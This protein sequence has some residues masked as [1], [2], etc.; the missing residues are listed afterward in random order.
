PAHVLEQKIDLAASDDRCR[1]VQD[2]KPH[3]ADQGFRDLDHLLIGKRQFVNPGVGWNIH[4]ELCEDFSGADVAGAVRN[5]TKPAA[6]LR[7]DQNVLG[8]RKFGKKRSS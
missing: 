6:G 5:E 7:I 1:L 3:P 4:A 2:E 8:D